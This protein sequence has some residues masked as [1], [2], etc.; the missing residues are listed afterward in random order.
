MFLL[1]QCLGATCM[2]TDD[3]GDDYFVIRHVHS[4]DGGESFSMPSVSLPGGVIHDV[5]AVVE[6][7]G[8]VHVVYEDWSEGSFDAVWS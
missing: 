6:M 7:C 1:S 5:Q 4:D 2:A 3:P 8:R